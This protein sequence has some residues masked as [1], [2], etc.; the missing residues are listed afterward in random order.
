MYASI[1]NNAMLSTVPVKSL[2]TLSHSSDWEG[3]SKLLTD[4]VYTVAPVMHHCCGS[5]DVPLFFFA[6][7]E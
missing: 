3:V 5:A 4:T 2:D 1:I 6:T 7:W